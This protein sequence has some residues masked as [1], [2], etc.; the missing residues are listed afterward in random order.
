ME[1]GLICLIFITLMTFMHYILADNVSTGVD[2]DFLLVIFKLLM[3]LKFM[4]LSKFVPSYIHVLFGSQQTWKGH[5][6]KNMPWRFYRRTSLRGFTRTSDYRWS[7]VV[8]EG[9]NPI[10]VCYCEA[11]TSFSSAMPLYLSL[12]QVFCFLFLRQGSLISR[13]LPMKMSKIQ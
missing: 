10:L 1:Q 6:Y 9:L 3:M 12:Q 2:Q 13:V 7:V 11:V 8:H 5:N 4:L